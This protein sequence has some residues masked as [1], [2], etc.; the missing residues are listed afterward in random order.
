MSHAYRSFIGPAR[1][2]FEDGEKVEIG[3]NRMIRSPDPQS[4]LEFVEHGGNSI[5]AGRSDIQDIEERM[6]VMG[7]DLLVRRPGNATATASAIDEART[8]SQLGLMVEMIEAG[9]NRALGLTAKFMGDAM[10]KGGTVGIWRD[11][12]VLSNSVE[13]AKM[14]AELRRDRQISYETFIVELKRRGLLPEELDTDLEQARIEQEIMD[15]LSSDNGRLGD[16]TDDDPNIAD[17]RS[18]ES[19]IS[20]SSPSQAALNDAAARHSVYLNRYS[21]GLLERILTLLRRSDD[22]LDPK[23]RHNS[24]P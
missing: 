5:S 8:D 9:I 4:R 12:S 2:D 6:A 14:L 22:R 3:P 1:A 19:R 17:D 10:G 24:T 20:R 16:Q 18:D 7:L 13:F 23:Y 15:I 21:N 11:Y